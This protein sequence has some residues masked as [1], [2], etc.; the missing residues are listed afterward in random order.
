[1]HFEG[2]YKIKAQRQKV[3][4]YVSDPRNAMEYV[5]LM[6]QVTV[7]NDNNFSI[8]VGVA[9]GSMSGTFQLEVEITEEI[10]P[11]HVKFKASG[12]GIKSTANGE[13]IVDLFDSPNGNTVLKWTADGDVGGLIAGVG[14]RLL[15]MAANKSMKD[16]FNQLRS[17][18]EDGKKVKNEK[19]VAAKLK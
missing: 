9:V 7:H 18:L 19:I 11:R 10:P 12:S 3:W 16:A 13:A 4:E 14:Q 15:R 5:P 1:M 8:V 6:K 17:K 2:E